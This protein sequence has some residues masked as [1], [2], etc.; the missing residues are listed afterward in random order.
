MF[1]SQCGT[2]VS[3]SARFC[4]NCGTRLKSGNGQ[5]QEPTSYQSKA[6]EFP[7]HSESFV[8]EDAGVATLE[9]QQEGNH[10]TDT[11]TCTS[12]NAAVGELQGQIGANPGIMIALATLTAFVSGIGDGFLAGSEYYNIYYI[13]NWVAF[14]GLALAWYH[15]DTKNRGQSRSS[16]M[17]VAIVAIAIISIPVYLFRSRG[18]GRGALA[19]LLFL[20]F[21]LGCILLSMLGTLLVI[22][23]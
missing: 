18:A 9:T 7:E 17:S 19:T 21:F 1:C 20:L 8:N 13:A 5:Y 12:T 22:G 4:Q 2:G 14:A 3:D 11:S 6:D 23:K 15:R 16:G 10:V